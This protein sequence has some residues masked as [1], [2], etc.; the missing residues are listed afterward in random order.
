MNALMRRFKAALLLVCASVM[1]S[2]CDFDVYELPLPGG[3]DVGDNP[4]EVTVMFAD[5]LD[6]VPAV[7]GQGQRRQ[8][9]Q[10]DRHRPRRATSPR[11]RSSC[12][13]TSSCPTTRRARSARP[14]CSAR[15]SSRSAR[16]RRAPATSSLESGDIIPLERTRPQPRGR[17]GARRAQPAAQRRRRRPAEDH[18]PRAQPGPRGPRGLRPV[19]APPDRGADGPARRGTRPT[20]STRSSRSTGWRSRP[21]TSAGSIDA[22]LEELPSALTTI[23]QQRGDLVKMLQALNRLGD[24]GVRVIKASKDVHHR[25]VP[26]A[27]RRC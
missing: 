21:R 9:R 14:A 17:G 11:S 12:A 26:P 10:G 16:P 13:T 24:V 6:L 4:I 15:S 18:H 2:G 25:V 1:L 8:R 20:S 19:G 7:H 23:D 5:V 3:T 22:A 27:R